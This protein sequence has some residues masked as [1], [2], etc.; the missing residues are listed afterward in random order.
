MAFSFRNSG[1]SQPISGSTSRHC[2][3]FSQ[4]Y[5]YILWTVVT[6]IVSVFEKWS[7][8]REVKCLT[9]LPVKHTHVIYVL[10]CFAHDMLIGLTMQDNATFTDNRPTY[11]NVWKRPYSMDQQT[12]I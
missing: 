11:E 10:H 8:K 7:F 3:I 6:Y 2:L 5:A 1:I 9:G 12:Y 4:T